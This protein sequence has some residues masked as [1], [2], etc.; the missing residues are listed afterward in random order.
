MVHLGESDNIAIDK[1]TPAFAMFS[2]PKSWIQDSGSLTVGRTGLRCG[3]GRV[4]GRSQCASPP[5]GRSARRR[6]VPWSSRLLPDGV[7][8]R[9]GWATDIYAAFAALDIPPTPENICAAIAVTGQESG[10][11][12]D[13]VVPGLASIARK[14]IDKR[15]ESAGIPKFALDAALAIPSAN[16]KSYSER[17]DAV[18]TELQLSE[19][20]EDFIGRVPFGKSLLA[21]RNPMR[22]GGPM[23]VSV[24]F[25]EAFAAAKPYPYPVSGTIRHEVF[26]RRGGMYFGIAH[27][28][29]YPAA[30]TRPLYRFADFNAG[31]YASRNAAFQNA[32]T[33]VSGIPLRARWRSSAL[34]SR[35][36]RPRA[37][38][39]G[40]RDTRAGASDRPEQ[41]GH[42]PR[43]RS[44]ESAELRAD[45]ALCARVQACR[46]ADREARTA[47]RAA[48][49]PAAQPENHAQPHHRLVRQSRRGSLPDLPAAPSRLT[50]I[51]LVKVFSGSNSQLD[52]VVHYGKRA[53]IARGGLPHRR[54]GA[55]SSRTTVSTTRCG[56]TR[57]SGSRAPGRKCS[58]NRNTD[59]ASRSFG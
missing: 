23:Q 20:Y 3:V 19:V 14:E 37:R 39:H 28:L 21:D 59:C 42:S 9:A 26:T 5:T 51:A 52:F 31:Q 53:E 48:A 47:R 55:C 57:I 32:V 58:S 6:G 45:P 46:Q 12:V 49:D 11:Q 24:A 35:A 27:L 18:K 56:R 29:D 10:F 30:Y 43:S 17:L 8:D 13:P 25:A 36:A 40:A 7:K 4:R 44:R 50:A 33:Q 2:T 38:Q 22:T 15:R 1:I 54:K 34:R 41:R 16:G